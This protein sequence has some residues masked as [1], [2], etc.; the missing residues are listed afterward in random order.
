MQITTLQ[1]HEIYVL[2]FHC[3]PQETLTHTATSATSVDI[4]KPHHYYQKTS[5]VIDDRRKTELILSKTYTLGVCFRA[6]GLPSAVRSSCRNRVPRVLVLPYNPTMPQTN[7]LNHW[8]VTLS[9]VIVLRS[10]PNPI[11]D[12]SA[13]A[14]ERHSG[15]V[16]TQRNS[17]LPSD[18]A[19]TPVLHLR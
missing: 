2:L 12:P 11:S 17:H 7:S 13:I 4:C 3:L 1:I 18:S 5:S 19:R 9:L 14:I 6:N 8:H 16:P 15:H 10:P